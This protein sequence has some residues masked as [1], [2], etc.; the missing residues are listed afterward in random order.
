MH[1][2]FRMALTYPQRFFNYNIISY[3]SCNTFY[4]Y[5]VLKKLE[6]TQPKKITANTLILIKQDIYLDK[7]FKNFSN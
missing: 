7:L 4:E 5:M 3:F 1:L 2:Y 6:N